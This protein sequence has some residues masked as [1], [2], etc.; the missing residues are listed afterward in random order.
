MGGSSSPAANRR[1]A[2]GATDLT[3][4][5]ELYD[6][7]TRTCR[8]PGRYP[9]GEQAHTATLLGDGRVLVVGGETS[10]TRGDGV[11]RIA[12]FVAGAPAASAEIDDPR[13]ATG[14][15]RPICRIRAAHTATL[16]SG[17]QLRRWRLWPERSAAQHGAALHASRQ[18]LDP[19]RHANGPRR[20]YRHAAA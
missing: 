13:F 4:S 9:R 17:G 14:N 2:S 6:P 20:A 10:L 18:P 12:L 3:A 15:Q 11:T 7:T 1:G 16:L 5:A 8:R 19:A